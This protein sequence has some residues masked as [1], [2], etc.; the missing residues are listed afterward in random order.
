MQRLGGLWL[1]EDENSGT[2]HASPR[3]FG[4]TNF[5]KSPAHRVCSHLGLRLLTHKPK[6]FPSSPPDLRPPNNKQ[7]LRT[8]LEPSPSSLTQSSTS[9]EMLIKSG[10]SCC[11]HLPESRDWVW[12]TTAEMNFISP[13]VENYSVY[14]TECWLKSQTPPL[15]L[16]CFAK[17]F[18]N[19]FVKDSWNLWFDCSKTINV[20][21][22]TLNIAW[23]LWPMYYWW[24]RQL[25]G[26]RW[27]A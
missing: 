1:T 18:G 17:R 11:S 3:R 5:W 22:F 14:Y 8:A 4:F 19:C 15:S 23:K 20:L 25:S 27:N 2:Q 21:L 7:S 16:S 13:N 10:N 9:S 24:V 12:E 26:F 6:S